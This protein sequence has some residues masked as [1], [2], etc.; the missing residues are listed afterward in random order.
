MAKKLFLIATCFVLSS[1]L[2]LAGNVISAQAEKT[3]KI[4]LAYHFPYGSVE[5]KQM[6]LWTKK[7]E[8][9]SKGKIKFKIYGAGVLAKGPETYK[10]IT[11]GVADMGAGY[12]YGIGA[13]FSDELFATA[14]MGTPSVAVSTRVIDDL[15][16]KY[17]PY[18]EKEWGNTKV[19]WMHAD[20][21][22]IIISNKPIRTP[23]DAKNLEVRAPIRPMAEAWKAMGAKPTAMPMSDFVIALQKGIVAGGTVPFTYVKSY[24]LDTAIKYCTSFGLSASPTWFC[25]MNLDKWNS[26]PPG[27]QKVLTDNS[28][29][30]KSEM[31][32]ALDNE[33]EAA[34][35][36]ASEKGIEVLS[37]SPDEKAA[38]M[39]TI[40]PVYL[41]LA[42]E[43]DTKG[44]P[45]T[46]AYKFASERL[47]EYSK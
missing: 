19:L 5:D 17:A 40:M 10:A 7:V 31:I 29:F 12:R 28:A 39:A 21:A 37:L 45:A 43:M 44:Y 11:K 33:V 8:E 47:K 32:K 36:W 6:K 41:K 15:R 2:M 14:L 4:S 34:K 26:L 27:L 23:D 42:A 16:K 35:Q 25:V 1:I 9:E 24:K 18:Y 30:G 20:P 22:S 3:V 38:M 46:E 13:P